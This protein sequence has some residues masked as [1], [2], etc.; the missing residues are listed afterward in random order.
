MALVVDRVEGENEVV[1]RDLGKYLGKVQLFMGSTILG[2]G[3]V[4]LLLDVYDLMSAVRLHAEAAPGGA[5]P[6]PRPPADS[7]IMPPGRDRG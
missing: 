4:V 5:T 2:T 1:V 3:D 7:D 6:R